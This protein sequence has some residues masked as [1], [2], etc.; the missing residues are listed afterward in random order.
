MN[1]GCSRWAAV[2]AVMC[3][4][5]VAFVP[6]PSKGKSGLNDPPTEKIIIG[7]KLLYIF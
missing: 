6:T 2:T 4:M 5:I 7:V 1:S 3:F